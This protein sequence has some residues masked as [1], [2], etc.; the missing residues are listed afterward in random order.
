[1]FEGFEL[2][3]QNWSKLS[4][5]LVDALPLI[6]TV[7][8]M[9]V[10][11]YILRHTQEHQELS[12]MKQLTIDEFENGRK[13]ADGSRIDGG[14]GL[15][16]PAIIDGLRRAEEHGFIVVKVDGSDGGRIKKFYA[17]RLEV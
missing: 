1:M 14:T 6:E 5:A 11:L 3:R 2:P 15:S 17:M 8:E 4:N 9:K 7:G 10:I 13:R 12:E 16:K